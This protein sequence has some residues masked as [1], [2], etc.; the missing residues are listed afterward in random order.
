MV[1]QLAKLNAFS[2]TTW[3]YVG[4]FHCATPFDRLSAKFIIIIIIIY[5]S[6][7]HNQY[8]KLSFSG[9]INAELILIISSLVRKADTATWMHH[10]T[11]RT[12]PGAGFN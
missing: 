2:C 1:P 12:V 10:V 7:N 9:Q 11:L 4:R 8:F 5:H 6:I 3:S